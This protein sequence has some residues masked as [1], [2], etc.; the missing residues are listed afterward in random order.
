L[1]SGKVLR[2]HAGGYLVHS[3]ES[4]GVFQCSLRSRLKKEGV[5]V[6]TGD[7]VQLD[8]VE[9]AQAAGLTGTA[10]IAARHERK[11][12]LT[13]PFL[14]NLDQVF[15][16]QSRHQPEWSA[17][18]CDRYI[19]TLQLEL[20]N[21]NCF[22]CMNKCDLAEP[23]SL[24]ALQDIYEPLGYRMF[25]VSAKT[26]E[27]VDQL[28]EML[29]G[30]TSAMIGP[31]GVGKSSIINQLVPELDLKV[32]INEDLPVGRHTTTYSE[33]YSL[34]CSQDETGAAPG[35]VADTPGF[36]V[37]DVQYPQ[38]AD[39]AWQFPEIIELA[40][41]CRFSNCLHTG[42]A[43][44][45]VEP[46]LSQSAPSRYESYCAIVADA[47]NEARVRAETSSKV[48]AGTKKQVGGHVNARVLPRLSERWRAASR[49]SQK[50]DLT[51]YK[52][53]GSGLVREENSPADA[54]EPD[55][56]DGHDPD[57]DQFDELDRES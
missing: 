3:D 53:G 19:V 51:D 38:P 44:C 45:N 43:G 12:L 18:L 54:A 28:K 29:R 33:L 47:Q 22:I 15:I 50:Q 16:V 10:V 37:A 42:E 55:F 46:L 4:P 26:G 20:D 17:L 24:K 21:F 39:V 5:S 30:K 57:G 11:N 49:R 31:S 35:W 1:I 56:E 7:L 14:A 36:I 48:D 34:P 32:D 9:P 41:E 52:K 6:F 27:G 8:E 40:R 25:F 13:R 2:R 23:E